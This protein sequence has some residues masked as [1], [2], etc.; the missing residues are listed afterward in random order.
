MEIAQFFTGSTLTT[1][2]TGGMGVRGNNKTSANFNEYLSNFLSSANE[3]RQ[4]R[5]GKGSGAQDSGIM[6]SGSMLPA[7]IYSLGEGMTVQG[8]MEPLTPAEQEAFE[9]IAVLIADGSLDSRE[10]AEL[11]E[12][13]MDEVVAWVLSGGNGLFEPYVPVVDMQSSAGASETDIFGMEKNAAALQQLQNVYSRIEEND[14]S[15]ND[16][17]AIGK[18]LNIADLDLVEIDKIS[19]AIIGLAEKYATQNTE[20]SGQVEPGVEPGLRDMLREVPATELATVVQSTLD[21]LAAADLPELPDTV[22]KSL[23]IEVVNVNNR[24]L[25][26]AEVSSKLLDGLN[27]NSELREQILLQVSALQEGQNPLTTAYPISTESGTDEIVDILAEAVLEDSTEE[28]IE[29]LQQEIVVSSAE[30]EVTP[31]VAVSSEQNLATG[32]MSEAVAAAVSATEADEIPVQN[33]AETIKDTAPD[34]VEAR[35]TQDLTVTEEVKLTVKAPVQEDI[36]ENTGEEAGKDTSRDVLTGRAYSGDNETSEEEAKNFAENESNSKDMP[37]RKS[38][39]GFEKDVFASED[40]TFEKVDILES[41]TDMEKSFEAKNVLSETTQTSYSSENAFVK[42]SDM[43][44]NMDRLSKLMQGNT[45]KTLKNVTLE[46]SPP[47]LGKMTID[48]SVKDGHATAAIKVE[49]DGAKQMLLNNVEQLKRNLESHGIKLENFEVELNKQNQQEREQQN[50]FTQMQQ[51]MHERH[52]RRRRNR[53]PAGVPGLDSSIIEEV[54]PKEAR[55]V[56]DDGT[57][58]VVA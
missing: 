41:F 53:D 44:E 42:Y 17:A 30:A 18:L 34:D 3:V 33:V 27:N 46:L 39:G 38:T 11:S 48:V 12:E 37:A 8:I 50:N 54:V 45:D 6:N 31:E 13:E 32:V 19:Q 15:D 16:T 56:R 29:K 23:C 49:T 36:S 1:G 52:S 25:D 7:D 58:D 22:L 5:M 4:A 21:T 20:N 14:L 26:A 2:F 28:E 9:R 57:V 47:E 40:I 24:I 35:N 43:L 10:L 51:E 55:I